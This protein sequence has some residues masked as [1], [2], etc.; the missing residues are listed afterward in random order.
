MEV[1]AVV[2]SDEP[3]EEIFYHSM[4]IERDT[5]KAALDKTRGNKRKA[6]KLLNISERTLI[7]EN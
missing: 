5:I 4:I 7:Q 3:K 6:A 2:K 1:E